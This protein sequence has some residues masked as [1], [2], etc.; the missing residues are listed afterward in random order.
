MK[1][2]EKNKCSGCGLCADICPNHAIE[3]QKDI[4]GFLYPNV[5][6]TCVNCSLCSLKCPANNQREGSYPLQG[7][8]AYSI[9]DNVRHEGASGGI[10]GTVA[11]HVL[12]KGGVVFGAAFNDKLELVQ[13][14]AE[15]EEEL[16]AVCK[17]K[18]LQCNMQGFYEKVKKELEEKRL[19]LVCNTPCNIAALKSFLP[20]KN[21][22]LI[23]MD[24]VC[25]GV[26]SQSF[27]NECLSW[28]EHKKDKKI[29]K[30]SF[31]EK[32]KRSA[33]P[34]LF[35][36][37]YVENKKE[38]RKVDVY[39]KDPFY[40]A[41]QKRISLRPSCYSCKYATGYR[42]SDITVGD[43]HT[44]ENYKKHINRME[45]VSMVLINSEKGDNLFNAIKESIRAELFEVETLIKNN[46]CLN[47]PTQFPKQR[48]IFF[49]AL[50]KSGIE[51]TVETFLNYKNEWKALL[52]YK[53]PKFMRKVV[54]R[55][56]FGEEK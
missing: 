36:I 17:S 6:G 35:K 48:E 45:G 43:F 27:F 12:K 9:K 53:M 41:F 19:V 15:K 38:K 51:K 54:K 4:E 56:V 49:E 28:Y 16:S 23:L 7:Y 11:R 14:K 30:Y 33:T 5:N 42:T 52:Y 22:N 3:L 50:N 24:F 32:K 55:I 46:E 20:T 25:H 40:L 44:I 34:H 37:E 1:S 2:I 39:L 8:M 10:F 26:S 21:K 13:Y 29:K 31:R 47:R 18:Y